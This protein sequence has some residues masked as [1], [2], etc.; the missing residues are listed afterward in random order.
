MGRVNSKRLITKN[1][2]KDRQK[3]VHRSRAPQYRGEDSVG[4]RDQPAFAFQLQIL[5]KTDV[6]A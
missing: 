4:R 5:A 1:I 6:L 3:R 2:H